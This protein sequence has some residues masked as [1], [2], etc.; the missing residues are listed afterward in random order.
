MLA[1]VIRGHSFRSGARYSTNIA[2]SADAQMMSLHRLRDLYPK[3]DIYMCTGKTK[4]ARLLV[5]V[6]PKKL[7]TSCLGNTQTQ[8]FVNSIALLSKRYEYILALR[9]DILLKTRV[10]LLNPQIDFA[11][12][13]RETWPDYM[14]QR[15][16]IDYWWM[17]EKR[18]GDLIH[19]WKWSVTSGWIR[20]LRDKRI[21]PDRTHMHLAFNITTSI[22]TR[23]GFLLDTYHSSVSDCISPNPLYFIIP[24]DLQCPNLRLEIQLLMR[25]N[26]SI[27]VIISK[28]Y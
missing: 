4:Y 26:I 10:P 9:F 16:T 2:Y 5:S 23:V 12:V 21:A 18:V 11:F 19:M 15:K 17:H 14:K 7:S 13:W 3:D 28:R 25:S 22:I 20:A 1:I 27:P 6:H 24:R 8:T